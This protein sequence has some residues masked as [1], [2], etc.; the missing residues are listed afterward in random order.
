MEANV[1][2]TVKRGRVYKTIALK[3]GI[4][5]PCEQ[6]F[7]SRMAFSVY[8]VV[9]VACQSHGWFVYAPFL[10]GR[11]KQTNYA[12][13]KPRERLTGYDFYTCQLFYI[14]RRDIFYLKSAKIFRRVQSCPK[15]FRRRYE[16]FRLTRTREHKG[17]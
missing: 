7:L 17:N 5:L 6:S 10:L 9:R 3:N 15:T 11:I 13:G 4:S 16:E 12:T 2:S 1:A 14:Y 8:E